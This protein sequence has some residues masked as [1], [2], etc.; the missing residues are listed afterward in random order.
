EYTKYSSTAGKQVLTI[1]TGTS[2]GR[3]FVRTY[4][5][6]TWRAW[7][8]LGFANENIPEDYGAKGDGTTDDTTAIQACL[9]AGGNVVFAMGKSYKVTGTVEITQNGT[10]ILGYGAAIRHETSSLTDVI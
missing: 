4:D 3:M 7:R 9:D 2:S 8:R 10:T 1:L 5:G 6:G